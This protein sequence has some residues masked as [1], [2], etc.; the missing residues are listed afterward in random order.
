[1]SLQK[2]LPP[3]VAAAVGVASGFYIWQ[4]YLAQQAVQPSGNTSPA[5]E[6][7]PTE[8]KAVPTSETTSEAKPA[9]SPKA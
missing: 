7:Q 6:E 4:P 1:M 3:L 5:K 8:S 9:E 2:I